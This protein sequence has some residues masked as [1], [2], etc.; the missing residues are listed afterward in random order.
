[1]WDNFINIHPSKLLITKIKESRINELKKNVLQSFKKI[2]G[3]FTFY[4]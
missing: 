3:Q 2:R 4:T 1:M